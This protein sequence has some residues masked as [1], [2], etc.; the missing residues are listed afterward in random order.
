MPTPPIGTTRPYSRTVMAAERAAELGALGREE[1]EHEADR[2]AGGRR[3]GGAVGVF[4]SAEPDRFTRGPNRSA[5]RS[6]AVR[7]RPGATTC[8]AVM[9]SATGTALLP[10]LPVAPLISTVSPAAS[11]PA[12][13][14]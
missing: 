1:V 10:R 11:R 6:R 13:S 5:S 2:S 9:A 12:S 3:D 4:V 14:P 8:P 7:L